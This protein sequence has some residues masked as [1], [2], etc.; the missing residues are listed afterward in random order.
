M[1][2]LK[3][4]TIPLALIVSAYAVC[5]IYFAE[6]GGSHIT[7]E[8]YHRIKIGMTLNEV[9]SILGPPGDYSTGQTVSAV[10]D[11]DGHDIEAVPDA[12][13]GEVRCWT[14]DTSRILVET[15][16]SIGV[17]SKAYFKLCKSEQGPLAAFQWR[18]KRWWHSG[19]L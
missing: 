14:S 3:F 1:R 16:T 19:K 11:L 9:R 4:V 15:D 5:L 8:N 7:R 10:K 12:P 18:L 6:A 2:K 13:D 17:T